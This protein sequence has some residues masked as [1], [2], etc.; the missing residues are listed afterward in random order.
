M[1][2]MT[3]AGGVDDCVIEETDSVLR[4]AVGQ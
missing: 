1:L 2:S 3:E 4:D